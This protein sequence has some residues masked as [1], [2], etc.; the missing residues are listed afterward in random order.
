[1]ATRVLELRRDD[2]CRVCHSA[3]TAGARA[4][5]DSSE[6]SVTCLLCAEVSAAGPSPSEGIER[7]TAGASAG[8]EYARRRDAR[9]DRVRKEHPHVG[10]LILALTDEPQHER[11]W[12]RGRRGEE[13]VASGLEQ[14]TQDG[15]AVLLHDRQIPGSRANIDHLAITPTGVYV[16]DA[17]DVTGKVV[18]ET[19][20]F[21]KAKLRVAGRDRTKLING[22]DHQVDIV[23]DAI[24]DDTVPV[25]GVLCFTKADL[26]L[27]GTTRMRGHLLIY[28]KALAKRLNANGDLAPSEIEAITRT[29][30]ARFPQA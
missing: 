19:P 4:Q 1:M 18:V 12:D 24:A 25:Q 27:I 14:R 28:R 20:L 16:V 23:R 7:G 3:L 11:A 6:K 10:G 2:L 30:V 8:R 13:A 21:G 29:L 22:L 17:K 26:P 15:P 9:E 5:W